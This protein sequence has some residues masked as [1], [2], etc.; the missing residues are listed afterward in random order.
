MTELGLILALA[1]ALLSNVALLCKYRGG[2]QAPDVRFEAPLRSAAA[3]FGSKWLTVGFAA[4]RGG[5]RGRRA[6][7][8]L[9]QGRGSAP[10]R[11]TSR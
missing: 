11:L 6:D 4:V 10:S 9:A 1:C 5:D 8:G 7:T 3:L 2:N